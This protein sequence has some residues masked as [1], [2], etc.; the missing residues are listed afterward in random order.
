MKIL[1]VEAIRDVD[2]YT[3]KNN[4]IRSIDLM[5]SAAES[6]TNWIVENYEET[7][8]FEIYCGNGNNGGDGLAIARLLNAKG[9]D[10]YVHLVTT[11]GKPSKDFTTNLKR[12]NAESD[13]RLNTID[14]ERDLKEF[15]YDIVVI[16]A[17]FGTGISKPVEG[18]TADVI[19]FINKLEYPVISIDV[20]SGL[21]C[22]KHN[23]PSNPIIKA[24]QTLTFEMPKLAFMFAENAEYVGSFEML[25]IGLNKEYINELIC[26]NKYITRSEAKL[27]YKA[28][29]NI[30]AHKG[31]FGHALLISGSLGKIGASILSA[32]ACL[33]AGAGLL[34]V[35]CPA[36]A[37]VILQVSV[38]EAMLKF[39]NDQ[40]K[41]TS[42]PDFSIYNAIGI[43]PGLG[44]DIATQEA[45]SD[46]I[47]KY[48]K[49]LVIDADALNII[50]INEDLLN[51]IPANSILTPHLKEFE[52]L[53]G[54]SE[55]DFQRNA[56]QKEMSAKYNINIVLKGAHTCIT[57]TDGYCSFNSTGTPGM[58]TAGSGDVLT[59]IIT[60]LLAQSYLPEHAAIFGV[61]L[62]GL[63][64]EQC[65]ERQTEESMLAGDIV[66]R[67]SDAYAEL[68]D[69]SNIKSFLNRL[70]NH[71]EHND[72]DDD[73]D[74]DF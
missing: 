53:F 43:G 47:I 51:H 41:I 5:E 71:G 68:N 37:N 34:T 73:D 61:F 11:S 15:H 57:T 74:D 17:I 4:P 60:G 28:R 29:K 2:A 36:S 38:P 40:N 35:H 55:N 69:D 42:I 56:L 70:F 23:S 10:V 63:A 18:L 54:V 3:I 12:L 25:D 50:S 46:F 49:P 33:R 13:F 31:N 67:I 20:P 39:D 1:A 24:T 62:H 32:K 64:G 52:R 9:Y 44:T 59:G 22:D 16:D 14:S 66:E 6:C 58:A 30:F 26:T 19:K 48:D 27:L 65:L 21:Y 72:D 7:E 8:Y 45:I